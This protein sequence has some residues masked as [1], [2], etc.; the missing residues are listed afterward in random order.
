MTCILLEMECMICNNSKTVVV[1]PHQTLDLTWFAVVETR[2][3]LAG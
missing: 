2:K 1:S 3:P